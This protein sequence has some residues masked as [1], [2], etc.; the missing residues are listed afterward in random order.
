MRKKKD[1]IRLFHGFVSR[2]LHD[3]KYVNLNC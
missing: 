2:L 3:Q 1:E